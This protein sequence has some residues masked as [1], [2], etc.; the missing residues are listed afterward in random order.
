[1]LETFIMFTGII[2]L[3]AIGIAA[4]LYVAHLI[5][6]ISDTYIEVNLLRDNL[7]SYT[8]LV[9]EL[10]K[11]VITLGRKM[12]IESTN[13]GMTEEKAMLKLRADLIACWKRLDVAA[14]IEDT[15]SEIKVPLGDSLHHMNFTLNILDN[16]LAD[17]YNLS[18]GKDC[19]ISKNVP[20]KKRKRG[21]K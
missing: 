9:K 13:T 15:D 6:T 10:H 7:N 2:T 8:E 17:H 12:P 11:D 16:I 20:T 21:T 14:A 3:I 19:S 1:M 4:L 18:V 5:S